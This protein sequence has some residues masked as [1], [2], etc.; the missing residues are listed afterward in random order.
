MWTFAIRM[1]T[2]LACGLGLLAA[3]VGIPTGQLHYLGWPLPDHLPSVGQARA[4]L[5]SRDWFTDT[6]LL[7][8][9]SLLLWVLWLLF[10]VSVVVELTASLRGVSAHRYRLLTPTQH[11]AAALVAGLTA[12]IA[13]TIPAPVPALTPGTH[14]PPIHTTT[15][16]TTAMTPAVTAAE[17]TTTPTRIHTTDGAR[18]PTTVRP[19]GS[20]TL[21]IDG[22]PHQHTV[23]AG[24]S[25]WH[26]AKDFL[27]DAERWQEIWQLNKGKYWPQVS[28]RTT[29]H[30]PDLIYPG[31][32]LT[33]PD[34]ATTPPAPHGAPRSDPPP[35][36]T[37]PPAPTE[38]TPPTTPTPQPAPDPTP[39]TTAPATPTPTA[40]PSP[41]T[42]TTSAP[43]STTTV[44]TTT[45]AAAGESPAVGAPEWIQITG[46]FIGAG[47]GAA[48]L[49]AATMVWRRRRHHYTPTPITTPQ[50]DDP[51]LTS[52]LGALTHIRH[53]LRRHRPDLLDPTPQPGPTVRDYA[54]AEVKPTL[55]PVGPT[56]TELAGLNLVA[57][58]AGVGLIGPGALA[59]ARGVLA[60][61]LASGDPNDPDAQGQVI[62]PAATLASLLG[63]DA[64]EVGH[65]QRL[66]V[67]PTATDALTL[68]EEEIIRRSRVL[69]DHDAADVP[70]LRVTQV[71][72]EPLPQ[73]LLLADV[74]E[75]AWWNRLATAIRLG[76]A[77]EI[78]A[79]L[80]GEWERGTTLTLTNDGGISGD[81]AGRVAVL[82]TTAT[83]SLLAML[84]E[85]HGDTTA[86]PTTPNPPAPT[87]PASQNP[88]PPATDSSEATR[89]A[90]PETTA[91]P[92]EPTA[93]PEEPTTAPRA[94]TTTNNPPPGPGSG[95]A[96]VRVLGTP[97]VLDGEGTPMR[98]LRAKSLELLAY[99]RAWEPSGLRG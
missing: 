97:T 27:G 9:L 96:P 65:M 90:P 59:A 23:A 79:T 83:T 15:F 77:V 71:L 62:V 40:T 87:T 24:E 54:A 58:P 6:T 94:H 4:A 48:L 44:P 72:A 37:S 41:S 28:G 69:A 66:R 60:A 99:E 42:A 73:L 89:S 91:S 52:P 10:T 82:D 38:A 25:L 53:T 16:A 32:V 30:D 85:A 93:P 1:A 2:R 64:V 86:T 21:L 19:V 3:V 63:V 33:L 78:T 5:T 8:G 75:Q 29:L 84:R 12:T 67:T 47:L 7:A 74:P 34:G 45:P 14:P 98:G 57:L 95:V 92:D 17:T 70:T 11:L 35:E 39:V 43:P 20:V 88:P 56:G 18:Q 81:G 49:A 46:G 50:L 76:K 80:I 13:A 22:H 51:D 55:P 31:W 68:L 61:A 36:H 26:I